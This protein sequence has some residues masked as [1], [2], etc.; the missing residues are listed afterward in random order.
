[1]FFS[2]QRSYIYLYFCCCHCFMILF[3]CFKFLI[4]GEFTLEWGLS[5]G[6]NFSI[7]LIKKRLLD[8]TLGW[9]GVGGFWGQFHHESKA[10]ALLVT[11]CT[12]LLFQALETRASPGHTPGCVTFVLD[13]H[14]MAFTG[15]TLL[16]RGCGRTD[17]QQ[18]HRPLSP[19]RD[20]SMVMWVPGFY[21]SV[22]RMNGWMLDF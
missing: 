4:L 11:L 8:V 1:M 18:G 21:V 14:S 15:D 16:I 7:F 12:L 20:L 9:D 2:N 19:A 5:P 3:S 22:A 17:F 13:D 10:T 6:S